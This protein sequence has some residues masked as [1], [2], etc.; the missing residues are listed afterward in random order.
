MTEKI[1]EGSSTRTAEK[2]AAWQLKTHAAIQQ[3]YT[4]RLGEYKTAMKAQQFNAAPQVALGG[5]DQLNRKIERTELKRGCIGSLAA[6]NVFDM[7]IDDV[8]E[9]PPNPPAQVQ[10]FSRPDLVKTP[11]DAV[12]IRFFEQAFEW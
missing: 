9:N 11:Q 10:T 4:A 1:A 12:L 8:V 7:N 2:F 5:S 3:A 6:M